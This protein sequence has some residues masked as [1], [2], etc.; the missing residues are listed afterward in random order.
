M[1]LESPEQRVDPPH[2]FN[3]SL[4]LKEPELPSFTTVVNWNF[5]YLLESPN[6]S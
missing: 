3:L 2:S 4:S 6:T 1:M 5:V